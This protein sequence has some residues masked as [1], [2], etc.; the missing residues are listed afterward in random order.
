M[1]LTNTQ[2][3]DTYGNLLTIGAT[4][5][6]PQEGTL[7]NGAGEDITSLTVQ[8]IKYE[9]SSVTALGTDINTSVVLNYGVSL[10]SA[11]ASDY[12]VRLPEPSLGGIVG[13]VNDSGV[14]VFVFPFDS[15]DTI[16]G[17]NAGE[18]Y[19]VPADGQLYNI[20]CV[21]NPNV[22]VWSVTTPTSN[23]SVRRTVS[24]NLVADGTVNDSGTY[25]YS[26]PL[27]NSNKTTY[28]PSTGAYDVLN[29]PLAANDWFDSPEFNTYNKVR[30]SKIIAKTNVPA[31]DL[32]GSA[33]QISSTLMGIT[34][35]QL[36][37]LFGYI[38]IIS[39][40]S[41]GATYSVNEYNL[42]RPLNTYSSLINAGNSSPYVSHYMENGTLYQQLEGGASNM[43]WQDINDANGNRRIY[44]SPYIGYGQNGTPYTG[45]PSGFSF[46]AEVIVDFEFSL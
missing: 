9:Q 15:N 41:N 18:A 26:A 23:N 12:A 31:G 21:Q 13:V 14:D 19:V 1:N 16:L 39:L 32:T 5:G 27:L 24:V 44:H 36:Q 46:E 3:E 20:T 37:Q 33:S 10:I 34:A 17:L 7:Q 38:R 43:G 22:G 8:S 25:S 4:A 40:G 30:I 28:Y 29:A 6:S 45:Y 42:L 35:V 2:I 11:T